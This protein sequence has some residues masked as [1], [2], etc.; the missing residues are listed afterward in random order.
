MKTQT[1][2]V[3]GNC[4]A[5][6]IAAVLRRHPRITALFE[7]VYLRSFDHPTEGIA[8]LDDRDAERCAMLFEQYDANAPFPSPEKL[9]RQAHR[10]T[11][12]AADLHLLWPLGS[13]NPANLPEPPRYP[14]G[15]FVYGDAAV[16]R[17]IQGGATAEEALAYYLERSEQDLPPLDK[18]LRLEQARLAQRDARCDVKVS[19]LIFDRFQSERLFWTIN[20]PTHAL[21]RE[22]INAILA[23]AASLE[24]RLARVRLDNEYFKKHFASEVLGA[25]AVPIHP[26]VAEYFVLS[27]YDPNERWTYYGDTR[28]YE[29][30]FREMI[31]YGVAAERARRVETASQ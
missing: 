31:E 9:P 25:I 15:R 17:Q 22:L 4:Q 23:K 12:P 5:E 29:A 26:K 13:V 28:T 27:W 30:Y 19:P 10:V 21:L 18:F 6:A 24:P 8:A 2:I 20:H 3:Y 7:I 16:I 1:L 14:H 11:F